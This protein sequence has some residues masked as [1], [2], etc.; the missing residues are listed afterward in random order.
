MTQEIIN[1]S[2]NTANPA[3]DTPSGQLQAEGGQPTTNAEEEQRASSTAPVSGPT[4]TIDPAVVATLYQKLNKASSSAFYMS[5]PKRI[6]KLE[7]ALIIPVSDDKS[8]QMFFTHAS[9]ELE[10]DAYRKARESRTMPELVTERQI[11][12]EAQRRYE[13]KHGKSAVINEEY[14]A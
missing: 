3:V 11:M 14:L 5:N 1:D 10:R 12:E 13:A 8:F 2:N 6:E 9:R 4:T 7:E